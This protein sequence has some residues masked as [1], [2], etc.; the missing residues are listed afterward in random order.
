[1]KR[2]SGGVVRGA[3][4]TR[5]VS[6]D[7]DEG[8]EGKFASLA[9]SFNTLS[10]TIDAVD[11]SSDLSAMARQLLDALKTGDPTSVLNAVSHLVS[12]ACHLSPKDKLSLLTYSD[13]QGQNI[14]ALLKGS[15]HDDNWNRVCAAAWE[16]STSAD[17]TV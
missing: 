15:V 10:A 4:P 12:A 16:I 2:T 14:T 7:G 13:E 11:S 6:N 8:G 3:S 1:M 9:R 5:G 17:S